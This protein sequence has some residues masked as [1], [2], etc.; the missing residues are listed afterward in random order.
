LGFRE[1]IEL[2]GRKEKGK[3][4]EAANLFQDFRLSSGIS[5]IRASCAEIFKKLT[6]GRI[7]RP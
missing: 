4:E 7:N 2:G 6:G 1:K 3:R 5:C